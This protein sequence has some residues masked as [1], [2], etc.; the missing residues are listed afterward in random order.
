MSLLDVIKKDR[1]IAS[2]IVLGAVGIIC[3]VVLFLWNETFFD[4]SSK[5]NSEKT[6]HFG[7]LV[8]GV[9][10][11]FWALAGVFLFYKALTE[12]RIDFRNNKETLDLQVDALNQQITEFKLS[13]D[14][15]KSTRRV[16]EEQSK[17]LKAQQFES[18]FYSL[19]NVYLSLK[20]NL[21]SE[22]EYFKVLAEKIGQSYDPLTESEGSH[23][24]NITEF[25]NV[26][27]RER[28][29]LSNYFRSFYRLI[30]IIESCSHFNDKEKYFYAKILRAQLSDYELIIIYYNSFTYVGSKTKRYILK[31][32]LLKHIPISCKPEFQIYFNKQDDHSISLFVDNF[33]QFLIKHLHLCYDVE[34]E[35]EKIEERIE[36]FNVIVGIY[37]DVNISI[38]IYCEND[39]K[40]NGIKLS[41]SEFSDFL[42]LLLHEKLV[43]QPYLPIDK[44]K[45]IRSK[46]EMDNKKE[47]CVLVKTEEMLRLNR[48]KY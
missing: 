24:K 17:T 37:F 46:T 2:L 10:G 9:F 36:G 34:N 14:E 3:S 6:G 33:Q 40:D 1:S 15:Q 43:Y 48:D 13:R 16:Y 7:D 11:S 45:L 29:K 19:L 5:I 30:S 18:N 27:S 44:I 21:N 4:F 35:I 42:L 22:G 47:F 23:Q 28:E 12:Q 39:I 32:N 8:G 41:E 25:I 38:R 31:Y 26:Y 20:N